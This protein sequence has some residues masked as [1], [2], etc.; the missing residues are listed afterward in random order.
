MIVEF[1][2]QS[3]T[4]DDGCFEYYQTPLSEEKLKVSGIREGFDISEFALIND[5][6]NV[7]LLDRYL[8]Y[9]QKSWLRSGFFKL[10]N[11][12]VFDN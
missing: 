2:C 1:I 4:R 8:K 9:K 3:L 10:N 7:R 11:Q 6:L 5:D 12:T